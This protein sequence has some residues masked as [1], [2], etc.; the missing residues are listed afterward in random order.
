M[1]GPRERWSDVN[2]GPMGSKGSRLD[3][4]FTTYT[5]QTRYYN[6]NIAKL[7][8]PHMDQI[9]TYLTDTPY[10]PNNTPGDNPRYP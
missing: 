5:T 1:E 3:I 8:C 4:E 7:S 10:G 9:P 2:A 6:R